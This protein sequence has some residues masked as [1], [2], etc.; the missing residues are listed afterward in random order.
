MLDNGRVTAFGD[1]FLCGG[2]IRRVISEDIGIWTCFF[3][4]HESSKT[5]IKY[6]NVVLNDKNAY[7]LTK[8][9]K[10]NKEE[11][12]VKLNTTIELTT[13]KNDRLTTLNV[14]ILNVTKGFPSNVISNQSEPTNSKKKN[15]PD[16]KSSNGRNKSHGF[17]FTHIYSIYIFSLYSHQCIH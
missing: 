9:G 7:S 12:A 16:P 13:R 4:M 14:D 1:K 17:I 3:A 2:E 6:S 15:E 5:V 11:D 8:Y 10:L